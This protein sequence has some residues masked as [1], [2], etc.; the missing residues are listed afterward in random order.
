MTDI[1]DGLT[2]EQERQ[3]EVVGHSYRLR[4]RPSSAGAGWTADIIGYEALA[5]AQVPQRDIEGV[6]VASRD[7]VDL[8]GRLRLTGSSAEEALDRLSEAAHDAVWSAVR[9]GPDE[10]NRPTR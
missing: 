4:A 1:D 9:L 5:G 10:A 7:P 3:V 2:G 8:V 6:D